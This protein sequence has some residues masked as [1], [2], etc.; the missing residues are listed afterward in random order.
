MDTLLYG[1]MWIFLRIVQVTPLRV[2]AWMGRCG[3]ELA[4]WLDGRHRRVAIG[5]LE[6]CYGIEKSNPEI[7]ALAR[8]NFR[9]LGENYICAAK[10]ATMSPAQIRQV[11]EVRGVEKI[12]P[13]NAPGC[14]GR[15]LFAVGHFGNFELYTAVQL[16]L[17]EGYQVLTTYRAQ[18]PPA[19]NRI[20]MS[21][22][23]RSGARFFDRRTET[24]ALIAALRGKGVALGLL[25]DQHAGDHAPRLPF[26]GRDCA[27]TTAPALF[28]LRYGCH[29]SSAICYRVGLA[30]WCIE[31]GD[32]I[33]THSEGQ[34]RTVEELTLEVNRALEKGVQ[35]D[36]ANWF[37][38]HRRWRP[39]PERRRRRSIPDEGKREKGDA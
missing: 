37:W 3:G 17:P 22:R 4:F 10:T 28:A 6:A 32:E 1:I 9:R 38:V 26:L 34:P 20:L 11:V 39:T 2:L 25:A 19:F 13:V 21:L 14:L 15:Y 29:L 8:E 12:R 16:F 7:R 23:A 5:N 33:P 31:F 27:S 35:R 24:K 36:P 18:R 30:R